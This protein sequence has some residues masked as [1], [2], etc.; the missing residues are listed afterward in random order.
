MKLTNHVVKKTITMYNPFH[1]LPQFEEPKTGKQ[2]EL[3]ET[4]KEDAVTLSRLRFIACE[5]PQDAPS[6]LR[7]HFIDGV[8]IYLCGYV[9]YYNTWC[10]R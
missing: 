5:C 6:L 9:T 8:S 7:L 4:A 3:K 10:L 1:S 2:Q